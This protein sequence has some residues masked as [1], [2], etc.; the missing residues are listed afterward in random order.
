MPYKPKKP[1]SYPGCPRLCSGRFCEE[2]QKEYDRQYERYG[3]DRETKKRYGSSWQKISKRYR[4]QHP[5]CEK[6]LEEGRFRR[7]ELVH[8]IV[9]IREGGGNDDENLMALCNSC[10][11]EIHAKRGDRWGRRGDPRGGSNP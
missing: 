1:C 9:P 6:C 3:R 11:S 10:H 8:H 5:L 2:H 4:E 7:A